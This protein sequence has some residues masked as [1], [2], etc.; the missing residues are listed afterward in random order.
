M[1]TPLDKTE[2]LVA[3]VIILLGAAAIG[4]IILTANIVM[5]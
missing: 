3:A 4:L 1:K 2:I 5:Q